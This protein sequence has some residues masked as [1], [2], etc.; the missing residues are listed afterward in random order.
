M[1]DLLPLFETFT[2]RT[3]GT[4]IEKKKNS[5]VWHYRKSDPELASDRV[6]EFKTVL[7]SLISD[8]LQI[9]DLNK[10]IEIIS[11]R[12]NKG[13]AISRL[14]KNNYDFIICLGDDISDEYMFN[15]LPKDSFSIKVGNK[16]TSARYFI[17]NP[18]EVRKLL[19]SIIA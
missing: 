18:S 3:P 12:V 15:N 13:V 4:F 16:N 8:E 19:K 9:L 2:D 11:V 5:I 7:T 6:V 1:E 14:L 10:A 17:Q